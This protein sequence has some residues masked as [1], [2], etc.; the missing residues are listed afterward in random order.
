M[1]ALVKGRNGEAT[2]TDTL[3][4]FGGV[5]CLVLGAGL[6]LSNST[7]RRYLGEVSAGE[8]LQ[9]AVPDVQRYLKLRGM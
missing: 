2:D 9:G 6:V 5:A 3:L 7:V 8:L 4:L 1:E